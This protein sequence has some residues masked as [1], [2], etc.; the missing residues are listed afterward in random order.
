M[1]LVSFRFSNQSLA[2]RRRLHRRRGVIKALRFLRYEIKKAD[3]D[4]IKHFRLSL[5]FDLDLT[6]QVIAARFISRHYKGFFI[7]SNKYKLRIKK[8]EWTTIT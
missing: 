3:L 4:G 8:I 7:T 6:N 1:G 2:R 5:D